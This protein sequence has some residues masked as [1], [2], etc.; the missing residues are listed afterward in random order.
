[1]IT[2][3][4]TRL[5]RDGDP[6]L[7]IV[8]Q[9]HPTLY[10]YRYKSEGRLAGSMLGIHSTKRVKTVPSIEIVDYVGSIDILVS[11]VTVDEPYQQHPHNLVSKKYCK[12]GVYRMQISGP[13]MRAELS[14]VGI[15]CVRKEDIKDSLKN[16][17]KINFDP[18]GCK[19]YFKLV[20]V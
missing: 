18:Y 16:R 1:M 3:S 11:C 7:R 19:L 8:E 4:S 2:S 10:R 20:V 15:M 14:N 5:W 13:P 9:P 12:Y 6:F 17:K